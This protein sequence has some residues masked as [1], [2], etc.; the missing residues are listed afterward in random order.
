MFVCVCA[1]EREVERRRESVTEVLCVEKQN[2]DTRRFPRGPGD[3]HHRHREAFNSL[4]ACRKRVCTESTE[5]V[6]LRVCLYQEE[7]E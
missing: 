5:I 7:R 4:E 1:C 6:C 3:C 2:H